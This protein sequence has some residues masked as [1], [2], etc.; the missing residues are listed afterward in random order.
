M[1]KKKASNKSESTSEQPNMVLAE[2]SAAAIVSATKFI[3]DASK[4]V[5][6][7]IK[8]EAPLDVSVEDSRTVD[9]EHLIQLSIENYG[10]HT[11]YINQFEVSDPTKTSITAGYIGSLGPWKVHEHYRP[12]DVPDFNSKGEVDFDFLPFHLL[13]KSTVRI[14]IYIEHLDDKRLLKKP[15]AKVIIKYIVAG[16]A[17]PELKYQFGVSIRI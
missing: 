15:Y 11:V 8:P 13:A 12:A 17:K 16:V 7:A 3:Y 1:T 9:G 4:D 6:T 10:Q 5:Y 14:R 2:A